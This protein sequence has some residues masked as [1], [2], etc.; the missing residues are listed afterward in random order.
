V[1]QQQQLEVASKLNEI[2]MKEDELKSMIEILRHTQL[3]SPDFISVR[4][5]LHLFH[6]V[7]PHSPLVLLS[8]EGKDLPP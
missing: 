6:C 1:F 8:G 4:R 2:K 3:P 5:F 7:F